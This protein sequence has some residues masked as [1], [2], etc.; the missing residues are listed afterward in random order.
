LAEPPSHYLI[1]GQLL[2]TSSRVAVVVAR[3]V[4]LFIQVL[5]TACLLGAH[6]VQSSVRHPWKETQQQAQK[7]SLEGGAELMAKELGDY[8]SSTMF[9]GGR[10]S[11]GLFSQA[12]P[13]W[14]LECF[15]H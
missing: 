11:Q 13:A 3:V 5:L 8:R 2:S 9:W 12:I 4:K 15:S 14:W 7:V 6:R 10:E 1:D